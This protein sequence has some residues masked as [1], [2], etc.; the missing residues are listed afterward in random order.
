MASFPLLFDLGAARPTTRDIARVVKEGGTAALTEAERRADQARY[1]EVTCRSAL[2]RVEGHAVRLDAEPVSR[3]HARL[4]L[5]L[6]A[7]LSRA[8]RD[9]RR[10]RVRVGDPGQA[11]LRRRAARAS[12]TA[13]VDARARRRRHRDRPLPAD[14]RPLQA[15]APRR[16]RR[17]CARATRSGSITKGPMVVRDRDVLVDA[18]ADARPARST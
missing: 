8:V 9:E 3:L 17:C 15:D 13:V 11:E 16:S 5:L 10:R 12:S 14:R 4:P 18:L 1:Q 6:R 7:P 2:N